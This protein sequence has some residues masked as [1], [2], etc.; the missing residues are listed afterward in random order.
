MVIEE[1]TELT[2]KAVDADLQMEADWP[3]K[4][5]SGLDAGW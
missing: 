4:K 2:S 5:G 1:L 3:T